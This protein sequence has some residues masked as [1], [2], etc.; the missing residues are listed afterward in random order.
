[1]N[2]LAGCAK[3]MLGRVMVDKE[4]LQ[5]SFI[6]HWGPFTDAQLEYAAEDVGSIIFEL[7]DAFLVKLN[8]SN[9]A[10][11]WELEC[12]ALPAI[13]AM[14]VNGFKLNVEY[15][16]ELLKSE[17][18]FKEEKKLEVINHLDSHG[19]LDEYKCPTTG[20]LLIHP[21]YSGRGKTKVKGFNLGSPSQLGV[22][23][24]M[25][26]VPLKRKVNE[27]TGKV[28][29]SCDKGILAFYVADF[30]V[31]RL[32]KEYKEA[33]VAC[34]YVEKL[35]KIA[36]N[37]PGNRIHARYN[38]LVRTGRMSCTEP[39]LQQIKK[40]KK[41]RSGFIAEVGKMLAMSDYSQLEIR[42]VAEVSRDKNLIDIYNR[43]LDVHTASAALM[44]GKELDEVS[45]DERQAA[46]CLIS[47][48]CTVLAQK[49]SANKP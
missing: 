7:Y 43:E 15:Y 6:D 25:L 45:K 41:H 30:E 9:L 37:Y 1:M 3:R 4:E 33:A 27:S 36:D 28:S 22:A 44:T 48:A 21:K 10:H 42:L 11:V 29:Y 39:N 34:Q 8:N 26:G 23:L 47:P 5:R 2:S 19:V 49:Q 17:T 24:A 32:Y 12:R 35:I 18:V 46:R 14:Y 38:Q 31:L 40:G 16:K 13:T 20:E